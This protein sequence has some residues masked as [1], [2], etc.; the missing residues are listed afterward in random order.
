MLGIA[1]RADPGVEQRPFVPLGQ[2]LADRLLEDGA[3]AEPLDHQRRR[4]LALAEAR[5]AASPARGRGRRAD[6][7]LDLLG[8]DLDLDPDARAGQLCDGR[9]HRAR[10]PR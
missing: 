8:R 1:D 7:A 9:L 6:A 10:D 4:R 2:R 5:H 3:E